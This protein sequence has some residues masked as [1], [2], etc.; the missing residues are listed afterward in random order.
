MATVISIVSGKGG[1]GKSL[2]TA[3]LGRALALEGKRVLLVD[4]DIFV[5]GLTVLL[6][7]FGTRDRRPGQLTVSDLL[8]VFSERSEGRQP[9]KADKENYMLHRFFECDLLPAVDNIAAP[10]DYDDRSLSDENY[11]A[12]RLNELI[13][14]VEG[15]YDYV[16]LDNRAGMDSLIA[17][18]CRNAGIVL[19]VSEDDEVGRQTN[20][21]LIRFLQSRKGIRIVYTILNKGRKISSYGDLAERIRQRHEFSV[22]GVIPFDIEIMENFGSDQFWTTMTQTLYFRA[23]IDVWNELA[24]NEAITELSL[25]RYSFPPRIFMR[26]SD[27]R[28]SLIERVISLYSLLFVL[29][30][31]FTWIYFQFYRVRG[32]VFS[33]DF[34]ALLIAVLGA[35]MLWFSQSGFLSSLIDGRRDGTIEKHDSTRDR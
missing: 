23:V 9:L 7:G 20:V 14:S 33:P 4:L 13:A 35:L 15:L 22:L 30:G 26:R 8:G 6:A 11:V 17:A 21:N 3:V 25:S 16:M 1:S 27:G 28:K 2:L 29:G 12:Q 18:S 5:R 10:L 31:G 32:N 24:E 34:I 19:S